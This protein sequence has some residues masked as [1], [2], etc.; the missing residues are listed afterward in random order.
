MSL[1]APHVVYPIPEFGAI[2]SPNVIF[3]RANEDAGYGYYDSPVGISCV[4]V[5]AYSKPQ[6]ITSA[7]KVGKSEPRLVE[8]FARKTIY[9]I[10]SMLNVALMHGHDSLVLSAFGCGAYKVRKW[11]VTQT[12]YIQL[13]TS[14]LQTHSHLHYKHTHSLLTSK[15]THLHFTSKHTLTMPTLHSR[16]HPL[17]WQNSFVM[18]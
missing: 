12:C 4:A 5:A 10:Q 11:L 6:I 15:H 13:L 14:T 2:Y 9:K 8:K 17:T 3:F 16:T 18:C 1:E 7:K